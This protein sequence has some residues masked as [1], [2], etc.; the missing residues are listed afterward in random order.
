MLHEESTETRPGRVRRRI[1]SGGHSRGRWMKGCTG[2]DRCSPQPCSPAG[3]GPGPGGRESD[4]SWGQGRRQDAGQARAEPGRRGVC[5]GRRWSGSRAA[6][7]LLDR[8]RTARSGITLCSTPGR[9][10]S[11]RPT[12]TSTRATRPRRA[13]RAITTMAPGAG[14]GRGVEN[15]TITGPGGSTATKFPIPGRGPTCEARTQSCFGDSGNASSATSHPRRGQLR[16]H[17]GTDQ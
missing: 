12:L 8:H 6:R 14:P 17:A 9:C 2:L 15:V 3:V 13:G 16:G 4:R 1:V 10:S 7:P 5:R 11:A